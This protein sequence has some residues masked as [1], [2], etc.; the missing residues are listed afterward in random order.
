MSRAAAF[1]FI[2]LL[3][4][5]ILP[6]SGVKAAA[7][8]TLTVR[9][10]GG[11][12]HIMPTVAGAEALRAAILKQSAAA[13]LLY[14]GGPV[15]QPGPT[16]FEIFWI[17]P[18]LQTGAPTGVS[19]K[20]KTVLENY[21]SNLPAHGLLNIVTQY[22]QNSTSP[23]YIQNAGRLARVFTDTSA[24]PAS[25]CSDPATP[26]N[27]ISDAQIRAEIQKIITANGVTPSINDIF[28]LFTSSGEGSCFG[29]SCA[30]TQF[31]AYH[32]FFTGTGGHLVV[33]GN[34]P[35]ANT[36]VCKAPGQTEP[37]G[38][39]GD[40]SASVASH[41]VTEATTDPELNAWFDSSGNEIGDL[42]NFV[43]GTNTWTGPSA[44]A[45]QMWNGFFFELQQEYDNNSAACESA[46]PQ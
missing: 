29:S 8:P 42:C 20:Y 43:F 38:D 39:V 22:F 33:Y 27:C 30:Y 5:G 7:A 32:S 37:N 11:I 16:I 44:A 41:E 45:N 46:G 40:L 18:H 17:P 2:G 14:H 21:A 15:I 3:A 34:E 25:G 23:K 19:A 4:A 6:G 31:C 10:A 28:L 12:A 24:Y 13:T 26:G 9:S 36:S 35:Y 1:A